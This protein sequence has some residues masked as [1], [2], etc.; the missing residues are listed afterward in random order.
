M[1][2]LS[3]AAL[4]GGRGPPP[5]AC[6][7]GGESPSPPV[8]ITAANSLWVRPPLAFAPSFTARC[9]ALHATAHPLTDAATVNA[10][11]AESTAGRI[12][13]LVDDGA[14]AAATAILANA[15][16]FKGAWAAPFNPRLSGPGDFYATGPAT[17]GVGEEDARPVLAESVHF[18]TCP[19][20]KAARLL[21]VPGVC[22]ALRLAYGGG[23][24]GEGEED[25]GGGASPHY[26]AV[27]ILQEAGAGVAAALAAVEAAFEE[28][29]ARAARPPSTT[30]T[31]VAVVSSD[32][33][34]S[35]PS[36]PAWHRPPAGVHIRLPAFTVD[37]P[38]SLGPDL[39]AVGMGAA[40]GEG[41]DFSAMLT[42]STST[43]ISEVAHRVWIESDEAGTEAAAATAVMMVRSMLAVPVP[44][45]ADRPFL[46]GVRHGASGAWL[47]LGRVWAPR[48]WKG[49]GGGGV[50]ERSSAVP[51][52]GCSAGA[53]PA[54]M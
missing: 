33:P 41:A 18:M 6:D 3:A 39:A 12:T 43:S 49:G 21:G 8:T 52:P 54:V 10:W 27:V 11:C 26:E 19:A 31:A 53:G 46:F 45:H 34:P 36:P 38:S 16:Y 25:E 40:F 51:V 50:A 17:E 35:A 1:G 7:G 2:A 24:G 15:L 30:A 37:A 48:A 9:A 20:N 22:T 47:F 29:A 23:G 13:E 28:E 5:P 4:G 32:D 44:F 42:G 14:V